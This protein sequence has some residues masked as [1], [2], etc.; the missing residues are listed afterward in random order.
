LVRWWYAITIE[1]AIGDK[2]M[3]LDSF[4]T[5]LLAVFGG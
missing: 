5:S 2:R 4:F 1:E 3:Q